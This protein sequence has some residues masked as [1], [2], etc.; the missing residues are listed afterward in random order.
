MIR[1]QIS[2]FILISLLL[3]LAVTNSLAEVVKLSEI[4]VISSG[5]MIDSMDEVS[6]TF[7]KTIPGRVVVPPAQLY[8]VSAPQSGMI[9]KLMVAVGDQVI[10]GQVIAQLQSPDMIV[11]QRDF[12]QSIAQQGFSG[13][14]MKRDESLLSKAVISQRRYQK[15][16]SRYQQLA[17]MVAERRLALK[18][19]GM[20]TSAIEQLEASGEISAGLKIR[21][22]ITGIVLDVQ[23]EPGQRL[24]IS[25]P[26]YRIGKLNTLWLEV[27]APL[28]VVHEFKVGDR[29]HVYGQELNGKLIAIGRN[30]DEVSQTVLVRA[31]ISINTDKLRPGQYIQVAH[32]AETTEPR[33]QLPSKAVTR[34][35]KKSYIFVKIRGG[36]IAKLITVH[37]TRGEHS[38]ISGDINGDES[39]AISGIAAIKGAW[40]GLGG[41][42]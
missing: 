5:I 2:Q 16:L 27:N 20:D 4:Q 34:T 30:V 8:V 9:E 25:D 15:T 40:V 3:S 14:A 12:L 13:Q 22:P 17:A 6:T 42:D 28:E 32:V 11:A 1:L 29:L 21:S 7:G 37:A 35:G 36:F 18:L 41:G 23:V 19:A 39:I 24:S 26:L 38:I 33:F 10:K 31:K